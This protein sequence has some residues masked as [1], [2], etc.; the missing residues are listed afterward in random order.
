LAVDA[1]RYPLD[2]DITGGEVHDRQ[3]AP[4]LIELAG[5][6]DYLVADKGHDSEKIRECA[7]ILDMIPVIL[8]KTNSS[9]GNQEFDGYLYQLRH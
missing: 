3:I 1:N 5:K 9:K 8:R 6:A 2:F 7:R 4:K